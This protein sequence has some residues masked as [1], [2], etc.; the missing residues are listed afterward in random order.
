M[1]TPF[2]VAALI[3]QRLPGVGKMKLQKLLY[4]CQAW[5]LAWDGVPL[6]AGR[7]EAW[8]DG[9][10]QPDVWRGVG[11][12][13]PDTLTVVQLATIDAVLGAYGAKSGD[14]LSKLTHNEKPW[15]VA[16]G[17]TPPGA[18]SGAEIPVAA[19]RAFYAEGKD[20]RGKVFSEAKL[21]GDDVLVQV[22][23]D[24]VDLFMSDETVDADEVMRWLEYGDIDPCGP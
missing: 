4:Y 15:R 22:P 16:R 17:G 6:F 21:R 10:V 19:M 13:R 3:R 5:S 14:W 11:E 1:A 18:A 8:K 2:D 24:E 23:E 9:P 12:G 20:P 7:I